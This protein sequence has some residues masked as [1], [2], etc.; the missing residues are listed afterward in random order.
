MKTFFNNIL[1]VKHP[2]KP[3]KMMERV[4]QVM[5]TLKEAPKEKRFNAGTEN[6]VI[7]TEKPMSENY[8]R[9]Y[10]I[11]KSKNPL[12]KYVGPVEK[13]LICE[14]FYNGKKEGFSASCC[15]N[16]EAPDIDLTKVDIRSG[17]SLLI[18][19]TVNGINYEK[20]TT[21]LSASKEQWYEW[22]RKDGNPLYFNKL[23]MDG[24]FEHERDALDFSY[25]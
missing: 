20:K 3:I 25:Q 12:V 1:F 2:T 22:T 17:T 16:P 11:I 15:T 21:F 13:Y 19:I 23:F 5:G 10:H 14:C 18:V 6:T 7:L 8:K 4:W 9:I 24:L